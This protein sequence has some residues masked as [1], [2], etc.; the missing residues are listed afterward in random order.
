VKKACTMFFAALFFIA[1]LALPA[2]A[3][4]GDGCTAS[5]AATDAKPAVSTAG[6]TAEDCA[7][8]CD[9][10]GECKL[11]NID[12]KGMTCIGCETTLTGA[13]EETD[14]VIKVVSISHKDG[15]A[16]VCYDPTKVKEEL[17]VSAISHKGYK[18]AVVPAVATVTATTASAKVA[19][20]GCAATCAK[21]CPSKTSCASKTATTTDE[22]SK[23]DKSKTDGSK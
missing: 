16:V 6:M 2:A 13:L 3:F 21:T 12:V 11:V 5:K 8:A 1:V 17:L 15:Q 9:Y 7:K 4:A 14:G 18:A 22:T 10:K 20:K 19:P 23:A